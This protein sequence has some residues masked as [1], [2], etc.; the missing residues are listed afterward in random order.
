MAADVRCLAGEA[1]LALGEPEEAETSVNS[2]VMRR[3]LH[4]G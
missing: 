1:L 2:P 3:A 4:D